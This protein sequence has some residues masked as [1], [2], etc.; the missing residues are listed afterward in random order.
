MFSKQIISLAALVAMA[1]TAGCAVS[2]GEQQLLRPVA[3][4]PF[5]TQ[6]IA[7]Y[8]L[9]PQTIVTADQTRL[10]GVLLRRPGAD[11]TVL[12]FGGNQFTVG[13]LGPAAASAFLPLNVNLMLVDH[14][15]YG[16]SGGAPTADAITRD[17]IA[18]FDHLVKLPGIEARRTVVHGQSLGS[19]VAGEVAAA[20]DTAGVVLES[21]VT[22][23]EAWVR[24]QAGSAPVRIRISPE[25]AGRGNSGNMARIAEPLLILVGAKDS[26]TPPALSRELY[27]LSPLPEGRKQLSIIAGA[28][29]NDVLLQPGAIEIYRQFLSRVRP[30][31]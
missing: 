13:K 10:Y 14:R 20:R 29:H 11:M 1:V 28:G 25:L 17:G 16:Q 31:P 8:I 22:T 2:V 6:Q 30:K 3:A 24:S 5:P 26:T 23:T 15:G 4:G 19:F 12:Y 21:S 18:V 27:A 9:E 7:D